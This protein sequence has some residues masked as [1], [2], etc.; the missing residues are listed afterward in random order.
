MFG[1]NHRA[2]AIGDTLRE[3]QPAEEY[4]RCDAKLHGSSS[5][6]RWPRWPSAKARIDETMLYVHFAEAHRTST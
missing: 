5:T 2:L 3:A 1:V 6:A 4:V